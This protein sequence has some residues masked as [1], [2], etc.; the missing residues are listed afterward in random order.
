MTTETDSKEYPSTDTDGEIVKTAKIPGVAGKQIKLGSLG[1]QLASGIKGAKTTATVSMSY[2]NTKFDVAAWAVTS[3]DYQPLTY[4]KYSYTAT[5]ET[6]VTLSWT[7][8]TNNAKSAAKMKEAAY[9]YEY[10]DVAEPGY[11]IVKCAT[12]KLSELKSEILKINPDA[13][14]ST[15]NKA[16]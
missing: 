13:E 14:I 12:S 11:L 7:L 9:T 1:I 4:N 2:G 3:T 5:A 15:L 10:L 16:E 8:K 6:D